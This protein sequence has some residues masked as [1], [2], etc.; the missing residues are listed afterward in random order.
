[1]NDLMGAMEQQLGFKA[2]DIKSYSPL[3]LAYIGDG[4]FDLIIRSYVLNKGNMQVNKLH[5]HTSSI[6]KAQ[7]QAKMAA[8]LEPS[9]SEEEDAIY[10]RGRNAKSHTTAKNAS[11][12]DYRKATGFEALLGYLYLKGQNDRLMELVKM[13]LTEIGEI[14]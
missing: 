2:V 10:K 3:A 8:F 5:R 4:V 11:V 7:T 14:K 6:V 1:M 9:L 13:A 12:G